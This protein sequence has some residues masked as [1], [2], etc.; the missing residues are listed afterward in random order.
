MLFV[1]VSHIK[2]ILNKDDHLIMEKGY[3]Y[4][5]NYYYRKKVGCIPKVPHLLL[6]VDAVTFLYC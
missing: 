5:Y 2:N 6:S 1:H 3:L 4:L